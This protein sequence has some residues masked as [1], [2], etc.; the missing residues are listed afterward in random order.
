[1]EDQ[2]KA[3]VVK[4]DT[5]PMS[6]AMVPIAEGLIEKVEAQA[7]FLS[8]VLKMLPRVCHNRNIVDMGG[9][10]Y[11]DDDG[12]QKMARLSELSFSEPHITEGYEP[13]PNSE[14]KE[15]VINVTGT[16][17]LRNT[18]ISEVGIC[19]TNDAFLSARPGLSHNQLKGEVRK[20][21]LSNWRGRCVRTILGLR[22][23]SWEDLKE[24]G[25]DQ[26]SAGSVDYNKGAKSGKSEKADEVRIKLGEMLFADCKDNKTA[27]ENLLEVLTSFEGDKGPV[28]GKKSVLKLTD[29]AANFTWAKYQSDGTERADY[30][31]QLAEILRTYGLDKAEK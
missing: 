13:I 18:T 11:I 31:V 7:N 4:I 26:D 5:E 20:K 23:L 28:K 25:F 15:Y 2:E 14:E 17:R 12:C 8:A 1:M 21:A 3:E 30:D 29:K 24:S 19:T 9:N 27:A 16:V 10:P 6:A 22:G